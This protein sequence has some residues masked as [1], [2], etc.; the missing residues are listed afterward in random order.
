MFPVDPNQLTFLFN[1]P[2]D[3]ICVTEWKIRK[4]FFQVYL[5]VFIILK[6]WKKQPLQNVF[7]QSHMMYTHI[8][9]CSQ[10]LLPY[11]STTAFW[12]TLTLPFFLFKTAGRDE[13]PTNNAVNIVFHC[14]FFIAI[15]YHVV[16]HVRERRPDAAEHS[17]LS[18]VFKPLQA[19]PHY[20]WAVAVNES[21]K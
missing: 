5:S 20:E 3:I 12:C 19:T 18:E 6:N 8:R 13:K 16:P 9:F 1:L 17:K 10:V 21:K 11:A 14:S 7:K 15:L 2:P 4:P